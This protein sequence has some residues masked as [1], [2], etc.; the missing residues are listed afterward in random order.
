MMA[1]APITMPAMAPPDMLLGEE[2]AVGVGEA[3]V[4]AGPVEEG[5]VVLVV[6]LVLLDVDFACTRASGMLHRTLAV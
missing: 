6:L 3:V 1:M 2:L 5:L 4:V